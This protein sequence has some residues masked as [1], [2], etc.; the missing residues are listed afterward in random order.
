MT[1][2]VPQT[3]PTH[4]PRVYAAWSTAP[5]VY[6]Y[7]VCP[8]P[9]CDWS[10]TAPQ[11]HDKAFMRLAE[12]HE[13]DPDDILTVDDADMM[14]VCPRCGSTPVGDWAPYCSALCSLPP[15]SDKSPSA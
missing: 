2:S 5:D 7:A 8:H 9:D 13:E 15:Y 4:E 14:P 3:S 11:S 1:Y 10:L 12:H 6:W